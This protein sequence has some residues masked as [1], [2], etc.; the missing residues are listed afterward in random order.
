MKRSIII[1]LVTFLANATGLAGNLLIDNV[2]LGPG[3]TVDL[4]LSLSSV[5]GNYVGLQFDLTLPEGFSLE[6]GDDGNVYKFSSSQTNDMTMNVQDLGNGTN[7]FVLYSNSLQLLKKG[8]LMSFHLKAG[9]SLPLGSYTISIDGIAYSDLDGTVTKESGVNATV[10]LIGNEAIVVTV[11]NSAR[12]YGEDNPTFEYTVIGGELE[13][14]PEI[15]CE[16][17]ESSPVGTYDIVVANGS[18]VSPNVTYVNGTLAITKAP[19]IIKAGTYTRNRDEENP[20]FTLEYEGFKRNETEAVLTKKPT[21]STK[22]KRGSPAGDYSV[23][24]SGAEAQNYEITYK[25]GKLTVTASEQTIIKGDANGDGTVNAADIVEVVNYIMGHP[26]GK[27]KE[28]AADANGDGV[29]NA[30]DIVA[31]VNIIMGN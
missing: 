25:D 10:I 12:E 5:V 29:V 3:E 9:S 22:A 16:A 19:L 15:I 11:K 17:T 21:I 26:S 6:N 8:D 31:I 20:E 14:K 7:R 30:A 13:G 24:V 1:V 18:V 27:F 4:K 23:T 2:S 28:N